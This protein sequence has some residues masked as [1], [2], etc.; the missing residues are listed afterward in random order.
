VR[1]YLPARESSSGRSCAP[2]HRRRMTRYGTRR[3]IQTIQRSIVCPKVDIAG[4]TAGRW[5]NKLPYQCL[6]CR[7]HIT[8]V[9]YSLYWCKCGRSRSVQVV[10]YAG[11]SAAETSTIQNRPW[12]L[13][14]TF[15]RP[16]TIS[17]AM[18]SDLPRSSRLGFSRNIKTA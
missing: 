15:P 7:R 14:R 11:S 16:W 4:E 12:S 5:N 18:G 3:K 1:L 17:P 6:G 2:S 9:F 10:R 13:P 8:L